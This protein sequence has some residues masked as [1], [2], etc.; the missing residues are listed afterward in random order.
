MES[1]QKI[2]GKGKQFS[3]GKAEK[4]ENQH[5]DCSF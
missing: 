1:Y 5:L 4:L 2:K 3:V